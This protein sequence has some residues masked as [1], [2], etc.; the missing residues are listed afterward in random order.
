MDSNDFDLNRVLRENVQLRNLNE[1]IFNNS[2]QNQSL[3]QSN[4]LEVKNIQVC[5]NSILFS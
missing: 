3:I 4:E 5:A 1:L 2:G